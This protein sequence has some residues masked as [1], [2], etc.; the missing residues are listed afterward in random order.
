M[1]FYFCGSV[2]QLQGKVSR[3][4]ELGTFAIF[5]SGKNA[6]QKQLSGCQREEQTQFKVAKDSGNSVCFSGH[7]SACSAGLP[8]NREKFLWN[9]A[10]YYRY[11]Q[12]ILHR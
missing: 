12:S 5:R 10:Y 2:S 11:V 4:I 3:K 1:P 7:E 6:Q 9:D 8:D